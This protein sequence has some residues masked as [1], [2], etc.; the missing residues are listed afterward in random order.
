MYKKIYR[1]LHTTKKNYHPVCSINTKIIISKNIFT[2][3]KYIYFERKNVMQQ[4]FLKYRE[5]MNI[6]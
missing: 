4:Y 2:F 1:I 6:N 3:V 5:K